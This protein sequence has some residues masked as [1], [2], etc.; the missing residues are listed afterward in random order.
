ML[1]QDFKFFDILEVRNVLLSANETLLLQ[2]VPVPRRA[3]QASG[4]GAPT[5]AARREVAPFGGFTG[6]LLG[7]ILDDMN[8]FW[9]P[10]TFLVGWSDPLERA[11]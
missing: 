8:P 9:T 3:Q 10:A 1:F 4:R 11:A 2:A 5:K 7:R 6:G